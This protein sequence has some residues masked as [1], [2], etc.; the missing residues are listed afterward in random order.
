MAFVEASTFDRVEPGRWRS[1]MNDA[2]QQGRGAYG[3]LVAAIFVRAFEAETA[4]PARWMR[5]LTVHF[6]APVLAGPTQVDVT[7]ERVGKYVTQVSGRMHQNGATVATALATMA[8]DRP[9]GAPW[10]TVVA[11]PMVPLA[12]SP[13]APFVP[14]MPSFLQFVETRYV[15]GELPFSGGNVAELGGWCRFREPV[16]PDTAMFAAL[17]DVWPPAVAVLARGFEATAS[18]VDL[19]YHFLQPLPLAGVDP[20]ASYWM[21]SRSQVQVQGYAEEHGELWTADGRLVARARQ[22]VAIFWQT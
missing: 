15:G 22:W 19:T 13:I 17:L 8:L 2:W 5:T 7:V 18:S 11:P 6:C 20:D 21:Q 10:T 4:D 14:R 3:G 1:V 9:G 12:E 16:T